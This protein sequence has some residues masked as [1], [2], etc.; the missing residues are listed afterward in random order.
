MESNESFVPVSDADLAAVSGGTDDQGD[1]ANWY[2]KSCPKCGST[3]IKVSD[4][5]FGIPDE[6]KCLD[7]GYAWAVL[8]PDYW[9]H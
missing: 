1:R 9:D 8:G 2:H 6:Q 3:N 5:V 4:R 7:C